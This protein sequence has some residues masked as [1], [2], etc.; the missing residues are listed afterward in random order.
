[1]TNLSEITVAI[2]AGG[3]GT[4]LRSVVDQKPKVLAEVKDHPFL[5]YLLHQLNQANFKNIVLCTG[6]LSD[7]IEKTFGKKYKN[8]R[9]FYSQEQK[10][11]GTAGSLRNALP[12]LNSETIL[13]MNGDSFCVV[14]F[15]KF[16]K[17]HREEYS[18][19]SIVLASVLDTSSFG[20]VELGSDNG[21]IGFQEKKAGTGLINAGI[22]LIKK[23][24]IEQLLQEKKLS[25]EHEVFPIWI[26]KGFYGYRDNN[27]FIDI[28]TPENYEQ[29]EQFFAQ[30]QM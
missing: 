6:Y 13:V 29:A 26:G 4:R 18:N 16:Y 21:I 7:Q 28:G 8:L 20:K 5:E 17:F 30:Y 9:L 11:L 15:E 23:K 12:L 27:N 19:A 10:P 14:D 25:L 1:M 22:Y 24:L 3:H 2:L